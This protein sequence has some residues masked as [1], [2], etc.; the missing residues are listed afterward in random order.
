MLKTILIK[1]ELP[2]L[3][4][5]SQNPSAERI[6]LMDKLL[7]AYLESRYNRVDD[8]LFRKQNNISRDEF[9]STDTNV[10]RFLHNSGWLNAQ[11]FDDSSGAIASWVDMPEAIRFRDSGGFLNYYKGEDSLQ[12]AIQIN[13]TTINGDN[14]GAT[15]QGRDFEI[16]DQNF[17]NNPPSQNISTK[18]QKSLWQK[19]L[20]GIVDNIVQIIVGVI[21]SLLAIYFGFKKD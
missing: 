14:Y 21:V 18:S 20:Q 13:N 17:S 15:I 1:L 4:F 5:M 11:F 7:N 10:L 3:L 6:A 8:D 9:K 2:K 12:A 19:I 16:R